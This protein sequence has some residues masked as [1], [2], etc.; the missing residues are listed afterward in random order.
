MFLSDQNSTVALSLKFQIVEKSEEMVGL[1]QDQV[2]TFS[3]DNLFKEQMCV[4]VVD[5]GLL[6]TSEFEPVADF[7]DLVFGQL[8]SYIDVGGVLQVCTR[9]HQL[10]LVRFIFDAEHGSN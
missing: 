4:V 8:T 1:N 9:R 5:L 6:P 7:V 10:L 3:G 2:F